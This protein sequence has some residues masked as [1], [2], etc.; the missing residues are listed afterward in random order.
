MPWVIISLMMAMPL[1]VQT[2][3]ALFAQ[4]QNLCSIYLYSQ[5]VGCADRAIARQEG[6][7]LSY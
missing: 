3:S 7:S 2:I 4:T 5:F 1:N 6:G